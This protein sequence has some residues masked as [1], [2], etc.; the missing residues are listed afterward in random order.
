ME[1]ADP[2]GIGD[3]C[4]SL[5]GQ[6]DPVHRLAVETRSQPK[7][8]ERRDQLKNTVELTAFLEPGQ[9]EPDVVTLRRNAEPPLQTLVNQDAVGEAIGNPPKM[10]RVSRSRRVCFPSHRQS[11][12]SE[13]AHRLQ[14]QVARLVIESGRLPQQT[15]LHQRDDAVE[16]VQRSVRIGHRL[17]RLKREAA[18]EDGKVSKE[19]CSSGAS[20]S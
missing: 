9:R 4:G 16:D 1:R 14:H 19:R 8:I 11:L 6:F 5:Q 12:E 3:A 2:R 13:L 7:P 10:R 15:L 18:G 20:R 17:R